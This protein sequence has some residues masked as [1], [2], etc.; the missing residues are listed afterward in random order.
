[1]SSDKIYLNK[2]EQAFL[3]KMLEID[4]VEE[5]VEGFAILMLDERADP[6]DLHKYLKKTIKKY[7]EK[8][9]KG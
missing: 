1:M 4:N 3:I 2:E 6:I 8:Y 9:P 7:K 5:A